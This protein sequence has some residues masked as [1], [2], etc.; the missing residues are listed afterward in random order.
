MAFAGSNAHYFP[1]MQQATVEVAGKREHLRP[2][3]ERVYLNTAS[4]QPGPVPKS[5]P[6]LADGSARACVSIRPEPIAVAKGHLDG[7]LTTF[8]TSAPKDGPPSLLGLWHEASSMNYPI[9]PANL[10]LAQSHIQA[11]AKKVRANVKVGAIE[12]ATISEDKSRIWM[13]KN[14]DF[15]CCDIY[16]DRECNTVPSSELDQFHGYCDALMDSGS[17]TIGVTETNSRCSGRRP[18][19][20]THVWSWLHSHGFASDTSSCFLTYWNPTG[21]ESGPWL[22]GDHATIDALYAIFSESSP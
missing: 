4:T 19:W 3:G 14:L 21:P 20:F 1:I 22:A 6:K 15:Y 17:A 18:Y 16:D 7:P 11:L 8:L 12:N 9:H 10:R 2:T 5:W 13:A